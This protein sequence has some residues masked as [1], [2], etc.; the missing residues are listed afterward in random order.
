MVTVKGVNCADTARAE[1]LR[2]MMVM[3]CGC[4]TSRFT[5]LRAFLIVASQIM[6]TLSVMYDSDGNNSGDDDKGGDYSGDYDNHGEYISSNGKL[7][8]DSPK[9]YCNCQQ[10]VASESK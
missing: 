7:G 6:Q 9:T 2:Q 4:I 8:N 5:C 10:A 1:I 3:Q